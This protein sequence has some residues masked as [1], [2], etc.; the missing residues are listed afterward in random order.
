M[1]VTDTSMAVRAFGHVIYIV[2]MFE[3][4]IAAIQNV[5]KSS[6]YE[7]YIYTFTQYFFVSVL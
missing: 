7:S 4:K 6:S 2:F 1:N 5:L 3:F